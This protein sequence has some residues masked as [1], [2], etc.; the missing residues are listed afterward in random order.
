MSHIVKN[1]FNLYA[2]IIILPEINYEMTEQEQITQIVE[3]IAKNIFERNI[4]LSL[5]DNSELKNYK[6]NP[7][8]IRYLSQLLDGEYTP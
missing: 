2:I 4:E 1:I 5:N 7:I 8:L 3:F 6:I